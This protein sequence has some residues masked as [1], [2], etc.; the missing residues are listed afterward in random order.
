M[1]NFGQSAKGGPFA[2]ISTLAKIGHFEY[3]L[4]KLPLLS[5]FLLFDSDC[6]IS[7]N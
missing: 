1:A 2:K 4:E 3:P 7:R 6:G 5:Q